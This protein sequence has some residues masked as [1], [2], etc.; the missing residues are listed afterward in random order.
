MVNTYG[1][2]VKHMKDNG[3]KVFSMAKV[4]TQILKANH[5]K[6]YGIKA[7]DKT[8]LDLLLKKVPIDI[9][10]VKIYFKN[11]CINF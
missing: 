6:E 7:K 2:T 10:N 5:A 8:G 3:L 4:Y 9:I 1:P 11:N